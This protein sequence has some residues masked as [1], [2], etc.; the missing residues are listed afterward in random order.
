[1][2]TVKV[3]SPEMTALEWADGFKTPAGNSATHTMAS[4]LCPPGIDDRSEP[5]N[6]N[7]Q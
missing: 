7:W 4:E 1:M 5:D 6:E 3:K 2:P